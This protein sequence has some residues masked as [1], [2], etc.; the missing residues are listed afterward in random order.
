MKVEIGT[1][2]ELGVKGV[3]VWDLIEHLLH[4]ID[5]IRAAAVGGVE[6]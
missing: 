1:L 4:R 3:S 6:S 5:R 2:M